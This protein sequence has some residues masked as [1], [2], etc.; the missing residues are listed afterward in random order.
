MYK[1]KLKI[2]RPYWR[3]AVVNRNELRAKESFDGDRVSIK[4]IARVRAKRIFLSQ[5]NPDMT[6]DLTVTFVSRGKLWIISDQPCCN[7]ESSDVWARHVKSQALK[8]Y[9]E[10]E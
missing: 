2:S 7:D 8:L 9:R 10:V 4:G 3:G 1:N 6:Y 5:F